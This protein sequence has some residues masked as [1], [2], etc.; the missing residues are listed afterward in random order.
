MVDD[1]AGSSDILGGSTR[2]A[3]SRL[4]SK[5]RGFDKRTVLISDF[6]VGYMAAIRSLRKH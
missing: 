1:V 6:L 5:L 4:M 3:D 2:A